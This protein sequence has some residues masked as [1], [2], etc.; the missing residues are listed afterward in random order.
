MRR[1]GKEQKRRDLGEERRRGGEEE[2]VERW[3]GEKDG[4]K[5]GG[6]VEEWS[7]GGD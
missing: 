4:Y 6:R 3:R 1:R 2:E 5:R 7:R